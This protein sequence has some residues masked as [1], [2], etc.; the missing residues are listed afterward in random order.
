MRKTRNC[1]CFRDG[2]KI[3]VFSNFESP[4]FWLCKAKKPF[5]AKLMHIKVLKAIILCTFTKKA[6]PNNCFLGMTHTLQV[7][8]T[9]W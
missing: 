9:K 2:N 6:K 5:E 1:P 8:G 7:G 3:L 4:L